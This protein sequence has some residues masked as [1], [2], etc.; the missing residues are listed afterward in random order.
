MTN[1]E[2][3]LGVM[4]N[5]G[6]MN[7]LSRLTEECGE[8]IVAKEHYLRSRV[9]V[10][11]V[12][13]EIADIYFLASQFILDNPEVFEPILKDLF[14]KGEIRIKTNNYEGHL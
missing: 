12:Y 7:Q 11:E 13:K 5:S 1:E 6:A 4:R 14:R 8:F 9:P 10:L 3:L 2:I